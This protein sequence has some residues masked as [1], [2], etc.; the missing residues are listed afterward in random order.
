MA[1]VIDAIYENGALKP[2]A[3]LDLPEHQRVRITIHE[4]IVESAE[5]TLAAWHQVY[6]GCAAEEIAQIEVIALDRSRFM[7]QES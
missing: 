5:E 6:E 4:P 2:L 1:R 3:A 7:Q